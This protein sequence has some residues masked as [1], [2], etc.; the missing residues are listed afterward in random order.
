M[1]VSS[2]PSIP[3]RSLL[4]FAIVSI[5]AP[6]LCATVPPGFTDELVTAVAS[7]TALAFTPD[8]RLL[9]TTQPGRL[10]V[11]QNSHRSGAAEPVQFRQLVGWRRRDA[12]GDDSRRAGDLHG[13]VQEREEVRGVRSS[14]IT[15]SAAELGRPCHLCEAKWQV[16]TSPRGL[17][18]GLA[19]C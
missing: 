7:P 18:A 13:D 17:S 6:A 2:P 15:A 4:L 11:Y 19:R 12:L 5:I 9:I 1:R 16:E 10:R 8:G 3:S 14:L